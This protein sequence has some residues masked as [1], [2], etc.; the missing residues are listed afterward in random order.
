M[1]NMNLVLACRADTKQ[2]LL[3]PY[4]HFSPWGV[5]H[6]HLPDVITLTGEH[7]STQNN[8]FM[9]HRVCISCQNLQ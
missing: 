6:I 1:P 3:C 4:L 2:S 9:S 8:D 5:I 7:N